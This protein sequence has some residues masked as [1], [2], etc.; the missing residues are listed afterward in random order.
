MSCGG[1]LADEG[2]KGMLVEA[3]SLDLCINNLF[4]NAIS[5]AV[6]DASPA[7]VVDYRKS[8]EERLNAATD[9]KHA[10]QRIKEQGIQLAAEFNGQGSPQL[11]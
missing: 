9:N 10:S 5:P 7:D 8:L 3:E 6:F 1:C 11:E 2:I 4:T